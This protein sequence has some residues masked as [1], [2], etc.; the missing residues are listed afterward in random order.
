VPLRVETQ[1]PDNKKPLGFAYFEAAGQRQP[2]EKL[3]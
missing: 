3:E 1:W 2:L